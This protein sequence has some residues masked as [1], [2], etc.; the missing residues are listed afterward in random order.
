[1]IRIRDGII[2]AVGTWGVGSFENDAAADWL[3]ILP[4]A[5]PRTLSLTFRTVIAIEPDL[6]LEE[7]DASEGVA[8]AEVVAAMRGHPGP[9][10][11]GRSEV[12]EWAQEHTDWV[13]P[14]LVREAIAAV[15]RVR[16]S[17]ELRDLW[18]NTE[19]FSRWLAQLEDLLTRLQIHGLE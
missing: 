11:M 14:D 1:M 10:A 8:A 17:S 16:S 5:L 9:A 7:R 2:G 12:V 15:E 18:S 4:D 3:A 19:H 6:Y 13:H